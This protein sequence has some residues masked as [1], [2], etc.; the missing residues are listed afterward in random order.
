MRA[1]FFAHLVFLLVPVS[2]SATV[3]S[4]R[5]MGIS[6]TAIAS[7]LGDSQMIVIHNPRTY[8]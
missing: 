8:T 5:M 2:A 6:P 4:L 3:P 7:I 1:G